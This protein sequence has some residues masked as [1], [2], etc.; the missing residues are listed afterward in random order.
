[1][2][3]SRNNEPE[4]VLAAAIIVDMRGSADDV[5]R[6]QIVAACSRA[7]LQA[8]RFRGVI[9]PLLV[10][11]GASGRSTADRE[12][13][14][15]FDDR[16]FDPA[17]TIHREATSRAEAQ[18]LDGPQA[19]YGVAKIATTRRH[20]NLR[21]RCSCVSRPRGTGA[22]VVGPN[23]DLRWVTVPKRASG[24]WTARDAERSRSARAGVRVPH[25]GDEPWAGPTSARVSRLAAARSAR[26]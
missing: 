24:S 8:H 16:L 11:T 4:I 3:A 12:S 21:W 5:L 9:A 6:E 25:A 22:G 26:S 19:V 13:G 23:S 7:Q 20:L 2:P 18:H 17:A 10:A 1:M 15:A 14:S